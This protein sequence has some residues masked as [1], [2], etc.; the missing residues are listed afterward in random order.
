MSNWQLNPNNVLQTRGGF[1][2][3]RLR[4]AILR[5]HFKPGQRLDQNEVA[6]LFNVSRSPV[7]EALRTL[8]AE[9]LLE[10]YPHRGAVVAELSL[11]ELEEIY[12]IRGTLE[13]TAAFL[14]ASKMDDDRIAK[15]Q[16]ILEKLNETTDLDQWLELNHDFHTTIYQAINR[17]RLLSLIQSLR[18][19]TAPYTRQYIT[20]P[21]HLES[22][23]IG[24][25]HILEAL[26]KR[27]G[28]LA[29][30]ETQKHLKVVCKGVLVYVESILTPS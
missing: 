2:V 16:T 9:G 5:G 14:A 4:E 3:D 18:N 17:P 1:V 20:S 7:R 21:E 23:R 26:I 25:K 11:A 30:E 27:D 12:F 22:T 19:I 8:A 29:Q 24:H 10:V 13:G 6:E 28:A 15:L